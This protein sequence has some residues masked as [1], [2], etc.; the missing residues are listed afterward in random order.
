MI[1]GEKTK[2]YIKKKKGKKSC[3]FDVGMRAY[4]HMIREMPAKCKPL[5]SIHLFSQFLYVLFCLYLLILI[6]AMIIYV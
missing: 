4:D 3:V 5:V 6:H 2:K 1:E